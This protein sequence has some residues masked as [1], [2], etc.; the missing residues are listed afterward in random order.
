MLPGSVDVVI[1]TTGFP[2]GVDDESSG[3]DAAIVEATSRRH[4][5]LARRA[6]SSIW[7]GWMARA[8]VCCQR[9]LCIMKGI[10]YSRNE[11]T[12]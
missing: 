2:R 9:S 4:G 5:F 10:A 7:S 1:A 6:M 12:L 11:T 3:G 8:F